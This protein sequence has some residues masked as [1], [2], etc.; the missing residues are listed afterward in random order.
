[1]LSEHR[2]AA[3]LVGMWHFVMPDTAEEPMNTVE[4]ATCSESTPA[5]AWYPRAL[6]KPASTTYR[7]PLTVI[8]VSAMFVATMTCIGTSCSAVSTPW[9][10]AP[11]DHTGHHTNMHQE[12]DFTSSKP[13]RAPCECQRAQDQTPPAAARQAG[14]RR[15]ARPTAGLHPLLFAAAAACGSRRHM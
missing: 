4:K 14:L 3:L 5:D 13:G 7:T 2:R 15:L 12:V 1:M 10:C 9:H 6:T 8:D 11:R